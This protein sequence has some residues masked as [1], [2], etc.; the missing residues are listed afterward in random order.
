MFGK[1]HTVRC[2]DGRKLRVYKNADDAFPVVAADVSAAFTS[3]ADA[4][5]QLSIGLTGEAGRT[6]KELADRIDVVSRSLRE[7]LR[8]VYV[9]FQADPCGQLANLTA[10]VNRINRQ[11]EQLRTLA[12]TMEQICQLARDGADETHLLPLIRDVWRV[13]T[14]AAEAAPM[15]AEI[16]RRAE[17]W[18]E[19]RG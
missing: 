17:Q 13:L 10:E 11:E 16:E 15:A 14:P 5:Q 18:R 6:V 3:T 9:V 1:M 7:R 2:L 8:A 12:V 4:A 19:D